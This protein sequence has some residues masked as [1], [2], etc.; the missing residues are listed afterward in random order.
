MEPVIVQKP[1]ITMVG[2]SFYGDPFDTHSG[3]DEENEIGRVWLRFMKYMEGNGSNILHITDPEAALEV[4]VYN[5]ETST[6]GVFEVFVG[7]QVDR[8][9]SVPVELL[10]KILPPT[11]YAVFTLQG[12][13]ISTDWHMHIDLWIA[14]A[15]YQRA[16]PFSFQYLDQRFKGVNRISESELD[17]YMPVKKIPH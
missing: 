11:I 5:P 10:V 17:V 2:M 1:E 12:E 15:G 14:A 16:H 8:I 7:L 6:K 3:W 9:E 13:E 4:H